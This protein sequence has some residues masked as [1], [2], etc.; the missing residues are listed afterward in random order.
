MSDPNRKPD[1][2]K[3]PLRR[4]LKLPQWPDADRSAWEAAVAEGD[5]LEGGGLAARWRETTRKTV[6]DAYGRWLT[7]LELNGWLDPAAW[8]A[9]RLSPERL[10]AFIAELQ[11]SVAPFTLCN[12]ITNLA[13]ALRVMAPDADFPWLRRARARLKAR[14]R[15]T[16]NKR[17]QIVPIRDL[18]LLGLKLTRRAEQAEIA[19]EVWRA[20][21]YRDGLMIMILACR[22]IRR[23]TLAAMRLGKHLVK[24]GDAY[25]IV[26]HESETKNHRRYEQPLDAALTEFIERYLD[27]YRPRLLAGSKHDHVWISWRGRPMSD[28]VVYAS[29]VARTEAAFGVA[30]PPHRF[31][32]SAVTSMGEENPE[33]VWLAPALLHH[34]DRRIAEKHYDQARDTNA[35][36]IWQRYVRAQRKTAMRRSNVTPNL[37]R[38]P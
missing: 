26:L 28:F 17:R 36:R 15:P 11:Q 14:A 35:V 7:F 1:P 30:V 38:A 16:R 34:S 12:R 23:R 22:P 32:D 37:E 21:L 27:H 18:F 3:D 25:L 9:D 5:L 29:I 10:R 2:K 6:Q 31:R 24:R 8:P 4:C 33:L 13:E 19:R 20:A